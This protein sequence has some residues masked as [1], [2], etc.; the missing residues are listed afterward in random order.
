VEATRWDREVLA[1]I[2][3]GNLKSLVGYDAAKLD[4]AGN[5]ELRCWACAAGALGERKPDIAIVA[6]GAHP[7]LPFLSNMQVERQ[8]RG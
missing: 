8:R 5:V 2:V 4:A 1:R 6:M 3:A 7:L